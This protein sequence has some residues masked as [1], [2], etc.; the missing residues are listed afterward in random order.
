MMDH[1]WLQILSLAGL[2]S[3]TLCK[4]QEY[5]LYKQL[6]TWENAQSYCR[7]HHIDLATVQT[8][9]DWTSL[10]EAADE[11]QYSSLAWVGLFN[12]I[13]GWRWSYN[14]ESLVFESWGLV[15]PDNYGA[16]E[17]CVT[18][19]FDGKWFDSY[20]TSE[21]YFVCYDENTNRT[22]KLVLIK[23]QKS[24]LDAQKYCR[25]HY[26]DLAIVRTQADND[27]IIQL[28]NIFMASVWMGLYRDTWKWSD[29]ANFTSSTQNAV[30]KLVGS[31]QNCATINY[32]RALEDRLCTTTHYFYCNTVKRNRQVIRVQVKAA[33][34]ANEERLKELVSNKV[35]FMIWNCGMY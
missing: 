15:Q 3:L 23:T 12:D 1:I 29:R 24:W 22:A 5:I 34:N 26:T 4:P 25:D 27:Q 14:E 35:D 19:A 21:K 2:L 28:L 8:D 18:I 11:Q 33:E 13:N 9:E 32:W 6:K 7:T 20:C 16:G 31:N 17:E 30:Q 10:K